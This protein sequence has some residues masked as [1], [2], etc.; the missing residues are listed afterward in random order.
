[1]TL[2]D[3]IVVLRAGRVEQI[4]TPLELYN[5]PAN[6]FVAGFIGAPRMNLLAAKHDGADGGRT[7]LMLHGSSTLSVDGV[8]DAKNGNV[9]LG[10]RPHRVG[11]VAPGQGEVDARIEL[12]E[13]L[14]SETIVHTRLSGGQRVLA[15]LAGQ[16][17]FV[18][19][20]TVGLKFDFG[21]LH[22]FDASGQRLTAA[23]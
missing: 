20:E 12:V 1:M 13:A 21:H 23:Q 15:V 5:R 7:T 8:T 19:G 22:L 18:S 3:R 17:S 14:G 4:G 10:V 2:A 16:H 9:T 6:L 11:L